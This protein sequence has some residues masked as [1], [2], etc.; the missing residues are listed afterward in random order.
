M[1][2]PEFHNMMNGDPAKWAPLHLNELTEPSPLMGLLAK[3]KSKDHTSEDIERAQEAI[4]EQEVEIPQNTR[5]AIDLMIKLE[6]E[7]GTSERAIAR[8]IQRRFK[9]TVV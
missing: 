4:K 9:I 1:N 8:I 3:A 2:A 7:K 6:R 5:A